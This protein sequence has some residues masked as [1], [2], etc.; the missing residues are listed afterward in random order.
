MVS[1][2]DDI[3]TVAAEIERMRMEQP[4]LDSLLKAFGPLILAKN[5]WL[6]D[7]REYTKVFPLDPVQYLGG[8]PLSQQCR[9]FLPEDPWQS[10]GL[11][12]TEAV[13]QGF[14]DSVGDMAGLA[15]QIE[16]G[17]LDCFSL[18]NSPAVPDDAQCTAQAAEL[19]IEPQLLQLFLRFL[20]RFMLSKRAQDMAAEL[21][22]LSW[23]KGY[24]PVC[25]SFP[26]LAI[27]RDKGQKWLQCHDC[28]H[29]WLFPRLACPCCEHEDPENT[30]VLYVEGKKEDTVYTCS[31]CR[32]YLVTSARSGDFRQI[33]ADL[34][35]ISL[36]HLDLI[37]QEKGFIPMAGCE[38][39]SLETPCE[40]EG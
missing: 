12:V 27:I 39:N 24:C 36:T 29:E 20:G 15:K 30:N 4:H 35:A 19:A 7:V 9:L 18:M 11:A 8:V 23:K 28:G 31:N 40:E 32:R 2:N 34:I 1:S 5:R 13:S 22:P 38:G 21:A 26:H 33:P 17:S 16:S 10:A 6:N 14:P 25:G 37:L 3:E